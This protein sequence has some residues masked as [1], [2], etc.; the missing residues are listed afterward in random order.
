MDHSSNDQALEAEGPSPVTEEDRA[1]SWWA[2][3]NPI[4]SKE[5]SALVDSRGLLNG[6]PQE[7]R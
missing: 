3:L 5:E 6:N 4:I 2:D 1:K 7:S